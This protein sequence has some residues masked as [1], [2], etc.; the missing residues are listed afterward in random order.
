VVV[1]SSLVEVESNRQRITTMLMGI[2]TGDPA[3][4]EVVNEAR[5]VQHNPMTAEGS[6]GL[7]EL[8]KRLS[9]TSPRVQ[10]I[11][12]F[13]DGDFV[14]AHVDYDFAEHVTGFEVFRF[15]GG[16]AVEHWDNLQLLASGLN[17]SGSTGSSL[18]GTLYW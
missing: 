15:E 1:G 3:S 5:Y 14:F 4:V 10:V 16:F 13:E 17:P 2:E 11:R 12:A 6:V 7:A 9:E 18:R 8:F